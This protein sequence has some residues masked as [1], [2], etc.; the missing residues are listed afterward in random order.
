MSS[1]LMRLKIQLPFGV[2]ADKTGV[3][4][5]VAESRVGSFGLL[6]HRLDC[7]ASLMPGILIYETED[8]GQVY[9]AIDEGVLIKTGLEVR[10]SVRNAIVGSDLGH[11]QSAVRDEFMA[12]DEQQ[13]SVRQSM[14]KLESN[15]VHRLAE[16]HRD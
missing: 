6:P 15:I 10:V 13:Q 1:E 9:M 2:F 14:A 8:E 16:L 7:V 3:A 12:L 11:L 5:I 4:R